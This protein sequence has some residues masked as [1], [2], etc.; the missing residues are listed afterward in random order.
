MEEPRPE[1]NR[2]E[3]LQDLARAVSTPSS[4]TGLASWSP[5]CLS[6]LGHCALLGTFISAFT[7]LCTLRYQNLTCVTVICQAVLHGRD[8][9]RATSISPGPHRVQ[10]D[11]NSPLTVP[12]SHAQAG[13]YPVRRETFSIYYGEA[14]VSKIDRQ[15]LLSWR[16]HSRG[17]CW[18]WGEKEG[19]RFTLRQSRREEKEE[20]HG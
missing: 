5:P 14:V 10:G 17:G 18:G 1:A 20:P 8:T 9:V 4:T 16:S 2:R 6:L 3:A 19:G 13:A 11:V 15:S 7:G 12:L